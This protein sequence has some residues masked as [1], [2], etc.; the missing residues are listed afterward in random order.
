MWV[1]LWA[2]FTFLVVLSQSL[3]LFGLLHWLPFLLWQILLLGFYGAL[4]L[5]PPWLTNQVYCI[6]RLTDTLTDFLTL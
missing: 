2:V 6:I 1:G 4:A 5:F 3:C